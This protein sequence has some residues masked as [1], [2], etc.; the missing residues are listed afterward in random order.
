MTRT[1]PGS[2]LEVS[3]SEVSRAPLDFLEDMVR[4]FGNVTRHQTDGRPVTIVNEPELVSEILISKRLNYVKT[5]TPDEVMLVPLLGR[6]LLTT[7]GD[8]WRE[9]RALAQPA[10]QQ[11]ETIHFAPL[12]IDEADRMI[13]RLLSGSDPLRLDRELTSLTLAIVVRSL[14]GSDVAIGSRF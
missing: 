12:M 1:P 3:L 7:D 6:G 11:R 10:F 13:G 9:Q 2:E 4:R 5:G 14:L 8:L